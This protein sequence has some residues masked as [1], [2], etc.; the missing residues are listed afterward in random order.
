MKNYMHILKTGSSST[1]ED[2][3]KRYRELVKQ[4]H[5]DL[6]PEEKRREQNLILM[7]IN[8]AYLCLMGNND[9][10][11]MR[12]T[13]T[14]DFSGTLPVLHKDPAY[15][16]Y[17]YAIDHLNRGNYIFNWSRYATTKHRYHFDVR[18]SSLLK[19]AREALE[20]YRMAYGSFMKVCT[21][22][23]GSV[24]VGDSTDKLDRI[25]KLNERYTEI[26]ERLTAGS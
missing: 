15:A 20:H 9:A 24:W 19:T 11:V 17:K 26:I 13:E 6:F 21:G 3:K 22:Y 23:P 10:D 16:W 14:V 25:D 5:P 12:E 8:E 7:E 4:N 18:K 2:L 1:P